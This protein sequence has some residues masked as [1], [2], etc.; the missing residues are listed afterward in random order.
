MVWVGTLYTEA[1]GCN[2]YLDTLGE[3]AIAGDVV[4]KARDAKV[5]TELY[6]LEIG[7]DFS[8]EKERL[9]ESKLS[10]FSLLLFSFHLTKG[11]LS[12]LQFSVIKS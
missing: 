4:V 5:D 12:C 1:G 8:S 3:V 6:L 9:L 11:F 7:Q 10:F 2:Y